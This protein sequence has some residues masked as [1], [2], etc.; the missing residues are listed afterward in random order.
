M[1]GTRRQP[2]KTL[3]SPH[4]RWGLTAIMAILLSLSIGGLGLTGASVDSA[5]DYYEISNATFNAVYYM[6]YAD[7]AVGLIIGYVI[8][9]FGGLRFLV[10]AAGGLQV[11]GYAVQMGYQ[12]SFW[13]TIIGG[14]VVDASRACMWLAT[15][16]FVARWFEAKWK[17]IAYGTIFVTA[18]L[19]A[20]GVVAVVRYTIENAAEYHDRLMW[21]ILS[22]LVVDVVTLLTSLFVFKERPRTPPG[23]QTTTKRAGVARDTLCRPQWPKQNRALI[24]IVIVGYVI[25][26]GATWAMSS[27]ALAIMND[28][29]YSNSDISLVAV[30]GL[31]VSLIMPLITGYTQSRTNQYV[32]ITVA[33]V[34]LTFA[35]YIPLPWVLDD[36]NAFIGVITTFMFVTGAYSITFI[37]CAVELSFPVPEKYVSVIMFMFAQLTGVGC[38]LLASFNKTFTAAMWLF[39]ALLAGSAVLVATGAIV[40]PATYLRMITTGKRAGRGGGGGGGGDAV[41]YEEVSVQLADPPAPHTST[42]LPQQQQQQSDD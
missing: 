18:S 20:L 22:F 8:L 1:T 9:H 6:A 31:S 29:N 21:Y 28:R 24:I 37:E 4:L 42:S 39:M 35:I 12:S 19:V 38:T 36:R 41:R 17:S 25:S 14:V 11:I 30:L 32:W 13:Y 7:F 16:T 2:R 10:Y 26:V 27:L 33:T 3:E 5:R 40:Y 15:P 34:A 23:P